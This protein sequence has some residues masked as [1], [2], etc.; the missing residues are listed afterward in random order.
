M[1]LVPTIPMFSHELS[2]FQST[3][4]LGLT[5]FNSFMLSNNAFL[6]VFCPFFLVGLVMGYYGLSES[7]Y[8]GKTESSGFA[9]SL[10]CAA[11]GVVFVLVSTVYT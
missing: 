8:Q 4:G 7:V 2:R 10:S 9:Y 5:I 11:L 1:K 3:V 6:R